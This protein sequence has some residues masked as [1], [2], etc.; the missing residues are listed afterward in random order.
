VAV[1]DST[2]N[3]LGL[4]RYDEYGNPSSSVGGAGALFGRFAY[5]G[6][7]WLPELNLYHYKNRLYSPDK[8]RFL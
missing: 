8:G 7:I 6:Q 2:G 4:N 5:T 3:S 1:L